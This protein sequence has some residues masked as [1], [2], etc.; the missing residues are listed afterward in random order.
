[1]TS[2]ITTSQSHRKIFSTLYNWI[3]CCGCDQPK[4]GLRPVKLISSRAQLPSRSAGPR[5]DLK[6]TETMWLS[7]QAGLAGGWALFGDTSGGWKSLLG[8]TVP[9]KEICPA[10]ICFPMDFGHLTLSSAMLKA[11]SPG[12]AHRTLLAKHYLY[13]E[14][15]LSSQGTPSPQ[16][17]LGS[18]W[19]P[20]EENAGGSSLFQ[21]QLCTQL[22]P[23]TTRLMVFA[24]IKAPGPGALSI[25]KT[26]VLHMLRKSFRICLVEDKTPKTE[27][28]GKWALYLVLNYFFKNTIFNY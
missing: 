17:W 7:H 22:C 14:H 20:R 12:Q 9:G 28:W 16:G 19:A 10:E 27:R 11:G 6:R 3:L 25:L 2:C 1:M 26:K 15:C 5:Q 24:L 23:I 4:Q 21:G 13:P 18:L 8:C